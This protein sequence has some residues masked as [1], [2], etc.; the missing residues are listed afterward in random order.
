M[1]IEFIATTL[2][3]ALLIEQSGADRI[4]LV[5]ALTEGG[6]T[7]SH[8]LIEAVVNRVSIPVNVM[9]RPHSQSFCY[10]HDDFSI[11]KN[12]IKIIRSLGANG[13]VLG[14]LNENH[15]VNQHMLEELLRE[16][17]GIEVTFHRAIDCTISPVQAA[18]TLAQYKE[19]T[20]ILTSGGNNE[21]SSRLQTIQKMKTVCKHISILVGSG[22]NTSNILS[23]HSTVQTG[24]YHFGT[25]VRKN[26]SLIEG[27]H[28]EK[29]KEMVQIL[30]DEERKSV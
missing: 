29:A 10:S 3:D 25:A 23:V 15:E 19:I 7:P 1:F 30:K 14:V 13:V 22:L 8:S 27:I 17:N 20:T 9:V 11:M 28:L 21:F 16:C 4:E 18:K 2:E 12:D 6:L 24:Y 26:H 5:S